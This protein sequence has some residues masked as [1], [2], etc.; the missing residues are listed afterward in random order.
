MVGAEYEPMTAG[1]RPRKRDTDSY[2]D[3]GAQAMALGRAVKIPTT[4][5]WT[6]CGH[7]SY[8]PGRVLD[9][10]GGSGTTA[11]AAALEGRDCTLI[12]LDPRNIDLVNRRLRETLHVVGEPWVSMDESE[13]VWTLEAPLPSQK[14]QVDGQ[15]NLFEAL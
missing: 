3:P 1:G 14:T 12:D 6:D 5:G 8:R 4:L 9:P 2:Q 11:V 7:D 15:A 13:W 10:F